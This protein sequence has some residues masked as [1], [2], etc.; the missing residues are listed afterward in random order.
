VRVEYGSGRIID[1]FD[2]FVRPTRYPALSA[3]CTKLTSITQ[4]DVDAAPAFPQALASFI[5]W[6]GNPDEC[7]FCSW[8]ALDRFL[9]RQACMF[10][11]LPFPFDDEY[12]NIKPAFSEIFSGRGVSM[13]GAMEIMEIPQSGRAHR[14]I[15]DARNVA[16]LWRAI[17]RERR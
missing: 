2:T 4:A 9:L 14:G 15:D 1:E 8:G 16:K 13:E 6:M 12:I 11:R 7:T 3:Y 5:A 10:H 17:L